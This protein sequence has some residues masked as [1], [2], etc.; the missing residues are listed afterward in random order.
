MSSYRIIGGDTGTRIVFTVREWPAGTAPTPNAL[1]PTA[2]LAGAVN[3]KLILIP[4]PSVLS[5]GLEQNV[6]PAAFVTD[7]ADGM[8]QYATVPGDVPAVPWGGA[9]QLWQVRA[10]YTLA[11][12]TG[13][14]EPDSF[15][16]DY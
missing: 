7:G 3:L 5:Q 16:V 9:P 13:K 6:V 2:N 1:A 12:W 10:S 14:S 15:W 11:G 4:P 8:I